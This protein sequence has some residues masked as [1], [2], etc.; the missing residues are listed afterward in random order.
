MPQTESIQRVAVIMAGGSGE[1]FWPVSRRLRPKQL[2]KLTS[3]DRTMLGEAVE[4]ISPLIPAEH[5]YVVTGEHLV[6]PIREAGVGVPDANVVAEPDKRN[7]AG[8][9]AFAASHLIAKYG[10]DGSALSLAILTADH[11]IEDEDLFRRTVDRAMG[12][13]E[14]HD[15]LATLGVTPT[16][17]E[18]GYGY[19]QIR[20][21]PIEEAKDGLPVHAVGAFHEKPSFERAED[22]I[23]E[24]NYFWNSG[25]FFWKADVFVR[26]LEAVRP[27]MA[28]GV[29]KMAQALQDDDDLTLRAVFESFESVSIDYAL[30]EHAKHVLLVPAT[31]PWDDVGAWTS[32]DR[33]MP[34]DDRNN[35]T[36]GESVIHESN[37]CIVY[38]DAGAENM[39]VAV[40]GAEHL[41]VV[42]TEDAVLVVPKDRAQDVRHAVEQL[43]SKNA[44]QV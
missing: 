41:V 40:I 11:I 28:E 33:T 37:D 20:P 26:E 10:G 13:A 12:T 34:R 23:R 32:L 44:K 24:G 8:A 6:A 1:R 27:E 18:T 36:V 9:L 38:N 7:T 31:F 29:E 17:P 16:R 39:A 43:K 21:E 2:L 3:Q 30:M 19:I 14:E 22:F 42:V 25:M 5:V 4:R 35:V 15:C